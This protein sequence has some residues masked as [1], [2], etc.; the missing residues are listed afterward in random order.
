[1]STKTALENSVTRQLDRDIETLNR[2]RDGNKYDGDRLLKEVES[3]ERDL[4]DARKKVRENSEKQDRLTR[5]L[6]DLER[7][8]TAEMQYLVKEAAAK[9]KREEEA[10]ARESHGR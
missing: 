3:L 8:M 4:E 9:Q 1:M 5:S 7:K 2:E 10:R 6:S